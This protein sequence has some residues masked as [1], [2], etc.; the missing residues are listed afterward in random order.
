MAGLRERGNLNFQ[1][2]ERNH[3]FWG[4]F[5]GAPREKQA[6]RQNAFHATGV[7]SGSFVRSSGAPAA[8]W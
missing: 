6:R 8:A 1:A 5:G 7:S 4:M 2:V 3:Y